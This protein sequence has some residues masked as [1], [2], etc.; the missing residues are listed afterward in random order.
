MSMH[1]HITQLKSLAS[2]SQYSQ[3]IAAFSIDNLIH[4]VQGLLL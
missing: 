1:T 2:T 3:V 4:H